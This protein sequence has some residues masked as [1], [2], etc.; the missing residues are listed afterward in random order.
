MRT[1]VATRSGFAAVPVVAIGAALGVVLLAC[2]S[3]YGYH[4][5]EL[6]FR[7]AGHHLAWGYV[8]QPPLTP[9]LARVGVA[10]FGDSALGLRV[11]PALVAACTVVVAGLL[12]REL[13]SGRGGQVLAAAAVAVTAMILQADHSLSTPTTDILLWLVIATILARLLA[14]ENPRWFLPLGVVVGVAM[15][16]KYTVLL[17]VVS[18]TI[19]LGLV[20]P[21]AVLRSPWVA[22]GAVVA[23]GVVFPNLLWQWHHDF[24]MLSVASGI[25][26]DDG[27]Q[28]RLVLVPMQF[29]IV[30]P[31]MAVICAVGL[32]R[33]VRDPALG[34]ARCLGLAYPMAVCLLMIVGGKFYYAF[35]LLAVLLVA[36]AQPVVDWARGRLRTGVVVAAVV[37]TGVVDGLLMLPLLPVESATVSNAVNPEQGAQIGWPELVAA[38]RV[39]WDAVPAVQRG[40]ATI[41]TANYGEAGAIDRFGPEVDLPRAYSG[42]MSFYEWGPPPDSHTGPVLLVTG[43]DQHGL[44]RTFHG[45]RVVVTIDN[46]VGIDTDEQGGAVWLCD[47]TD[48]SWSR[49][50]PTLRRFS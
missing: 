36:G 35:G 4:R 30:G 47:P 7:V 16:N 21:R 22:A 15:L 19:A 6:Y 17:L 49:L 9:V 39:G 48:L 44:T 42:H 41:V 20:G 23:L 50:W 1:V 34:F 26:G 12:A 3:R 45:C 13:R 33:L 25:G 10:V 29:L 40:T 38:V 32:H 2:A 43:S 8:D 11:I 24:P 37:L 18:V 27:V 5:D 46:G 14:E 31:P 28:N